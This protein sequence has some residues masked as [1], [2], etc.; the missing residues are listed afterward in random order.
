[1][2]RSGMSLLHELLGECVSRVKTEKRLRRLGTQHTGHTQLRGL[3]F[4]T[5]SKL[6]K[7]MSFQAST[8]I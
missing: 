4:I 6:R 2:V 7:L 3:T 1:M 5:I 8:E